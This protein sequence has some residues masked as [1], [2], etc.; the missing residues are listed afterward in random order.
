MKD[1]L[2][3]EAAR[4]KFVKL[5][6]SAEAVR[7]LQKPQRVHDLAFLE[8]GAV[9]GL[10]MTWGA[11]KSPFGEAIVALVGDRVCALTFHKFAVLKKL[12]KGAY[13]VEDKKATAAYAKA[14]FAAQPKG[15]KLLL[16]GNEF[17][18][19][20]W[21]RLPS[22]PPGTLV[23]YGDIAKAVGK[24]KAARAVGNAVGA[25]HLGWLIP[26]HRVCHADGNLKGFGWGEPMKRQ[27]LAYEA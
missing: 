23:R 8:K 24:P 19:A 13:F 27:M 5:P 1:D 25:N 11:H 7:L 20:V 17:H 12:F 3:I 26:C 22:I 18:Q 9:K 4:G 15:L 2:Y 16:I 21:E 6:S 10:E 14:A